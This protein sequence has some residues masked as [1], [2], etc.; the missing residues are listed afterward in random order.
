ME[1]PLGLVERPLLASELIELR[2]DGRRDQ[3][4]ADVCD[5]RETGLLGLGFE[6]ELPRGVELPLVDRRV[7]EADEPHRERMLVIAAARRAQRLDGRQ[8]HN[9][10]QGNGHQ[11]S[12]QAPPRH[13]R[14]HRPIEPVEA[15]DNDSEPD[16]GGTAQQQPVQRPPGIPE[17]C[18]SGNRNDGALQR[19]GAR[20]DEPNRR[21]RRCLR[22][23]RL[24][25]QPVLRDDRLCELHRRRQGRSSRS[26]GRN[27]ATSSSRCNI[28]APSDACR[29]RRRNSRA[30]A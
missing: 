12:E 13:G 22:H 20:C 7:R 30:V 23:R 15:P 2:L 1:G 16:R 11:Q 17:H 21:R 24:C 25:E 9:R 27:I 26:P 4:G 18:C 14:R 3:V 29:T 10:G 19:I 6:Q 28:S 8:E 5:R